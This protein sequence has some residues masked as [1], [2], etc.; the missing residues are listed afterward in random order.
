MTKSLALVLGGGGARGA[1]Q[2]GAVKA[3]ISAGL[4]P[5]M[6]VGTSIG[7]VN[8][9]YLALRG[10]N[11]ES[12]QGLVQAWSDASIA[13]LLPENYLWLGLRFLFNRPVSHPQ[14]H[15]RD[16][17][18]HHGVEPDLR[19]GEIEGVQLI[20]V[21]A[22]LNSGCPVL[23]G[24]D[25]DECL[26]DALLA[27]TAL[28]PWVKPIAR[29]NRWLVDGGVI[30]NLPIEPAIRMGAEEIV[31]L[32]LADFRDFHTSGTGFAPFLGKLFYTVET[33]QLQL[34]TALAQAQAVEVH[35]LHLL[36]ESPIPLWDFRH[37]NLLIE[38]GYQLTQRAIQD[39]LIPIRKTWTDRLAHQLRDIG[40]QI[41][42][43]FGTILH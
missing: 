33:R 12:L 29:E 21:S 10:F 27:S 11:Q 26:L 4:K 6:L 15:L 14:T 18:I 5:D 25:P 23:F 35:R 8:A 39:G 36:A 28:P 34:E 3:M 40:S 30:S 31:A 37:S 1:L 9:A 19:F 24:D 2:V 13:D 22:D 20:I 16:F 17:F 42:R 38:R 32:D 7:A 41:R 43:E